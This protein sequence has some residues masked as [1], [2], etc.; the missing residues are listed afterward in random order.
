V[1]LGVDIVA[2]WMLIQG[3]YVYL[4]MVW[5]GLAEEALPPGTLEAHRRQFLAL[6]WFQV[7]AWVA[8]AAAGLAWLQQVHRRGR[9]RSGRRGSPLIAWWGI[10]AA[11]ATLGQLA[12]AILAADR[13]TPL[14]L[15]GPMQLLLV[16]ELAEIGAAV[17]AIVLVGRFAERAGKERSDQG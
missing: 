7:G 6:R 2:A 11:A 9:P 8:I 10:L 3:A 12:V 5:H 14:D 1:L 13:F 15:G 16:A 17:L 4:G